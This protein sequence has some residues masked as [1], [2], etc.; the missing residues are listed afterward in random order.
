MVVAPEAVR[1]IKGGLDVAIRQRIAECHEIGVDGSPTSRPKIRRR[2]SRLMHGRCRIVRRIVRGPSVAH[3]TLRIEPQ[4]FAHHAIH[5]AVEAPLAMRVTGL[6]RDCDDR[7]PRT[8]P[9]ALAVAHALHAR[10]AIDVGKVAVEQHN[11]E[12][13][14][15]ELI[16]RLLASAD[17]D[18]TARKRVELLLDR[19]LNRFVVIDDED[20]R[21]V[22]D[23][24]LG[25]DIPGGSSRTG[26][27][28][29]EVVSR[30][31]LMAGADVYAMRR[32]GKIKV[33]I[34]PSSRMLLT[35][36]M[37]FISATSSRQIDRPSPLPAMRR[38]FVCSTCWYGSKIS[39]WRSVQ[40]RCRYR[41]PT[42]SR[43]NRGEWSE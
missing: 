41:G 38:F 12:G 21:A 29:S 3:L 26:G 13:R 4:R 11:V 40:C 28:K 30:A 31:S 5:A 27:D 9:G 18:R 8:F 16:A 1:R 15:R 33:K 23:Q 22:A 20:H 42:R 19:V 37:P 10:I 36:M 6:R 17:D 35:V 43:R 32:A 14:P 2:R 39:R 24:W 25:V 7:R 34:V